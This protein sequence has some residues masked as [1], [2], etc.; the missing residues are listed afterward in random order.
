VLTPNCVST[1]LT[2]SAQLLIS[3]GLSRRHAAE[4]SKIGAILWMWVPLNVLRSHDGSTC[5]SASNAL[6]QN[7]WSGYGAGM[8]LPVASGVTKDFKS[9]DI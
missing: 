6:L 1:S 9:L 8:V 2:K 7:D 5:S 4:P 3:L